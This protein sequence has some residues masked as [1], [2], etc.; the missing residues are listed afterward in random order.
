MRVYLHLDFNKIQQ[1]CAKDKIVFISIPISY[2]FTKTL[3]FIKTLSERCILQDLLVSDHKAKYRGNI[4]YLCPALS[5][6]VP[7]LEKWDTDCFFLCSIL[8]CSKKSILII[9]RDKLEHPFLHI[10]ILADRLK[11]G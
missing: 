2:S 1:N 4:K 9:E 5:F 11:I 6:S 7:K 8:L 3:G 10:A